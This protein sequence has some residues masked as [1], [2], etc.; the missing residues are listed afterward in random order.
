MGRKSPSEVRKEMEETKSNIEKS[1]FQKDMF[2][3]KLFI[4]CLIHP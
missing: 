2:E 3:S 4:I 1:A